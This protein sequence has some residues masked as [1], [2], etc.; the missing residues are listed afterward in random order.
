MIL[1]PYPAV[2]IKK[3]FKEE[4]VWMEADGVRITPEILFDVDLED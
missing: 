3:F 2:R 1:I 4:G